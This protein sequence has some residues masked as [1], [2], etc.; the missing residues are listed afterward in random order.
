MANTGASQTSR[1]TQITWALCSNAPSDL[2]RGRRSGLYIS[3][4][5]PPVLRLLWGRGIVDHTTPSHSLG[6][7]GVGPLEAQQTL[8]CCASQQKLTFYCV[9]SLLKFPLALV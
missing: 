4:M 9:L 7:R 8:L 5:Q 2:R 1:G 3:Y 6:A